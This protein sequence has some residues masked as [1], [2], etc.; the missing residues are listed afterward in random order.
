MCFV[1]Q[2]WLLLTIPRM[3]GLD[4]VGGPAFWVSYFLF[5]IVVLYQ[6]ARHW[7]ARGANRFLTIGLKHLANKRSAVKGQSRAAKHQPV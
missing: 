4:R 2:D 1:A 7:D 3:L 5:A 6:L